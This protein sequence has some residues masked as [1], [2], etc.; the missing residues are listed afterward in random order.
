MIIE[1]LMAIVCLNTVQIF[2]FK[3]VFILF[4]K[5]WEQNDMHVYLHWYASQTFQYVCPSLPLS[6]EALFQK[7]TPSRLMEFSVSIVSKHLC[8]PLTFLI[9]NLFMGSVRTS[10]SGSHRKFGDHEKCVTESNSSFLSA[11]QTSQVHP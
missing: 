4:F 7:M 8:R 9:K 11:L 2:I 3:V 10:S 6:K 5:L 1:V